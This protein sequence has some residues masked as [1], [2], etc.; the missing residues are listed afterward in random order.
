MYG[1]LENKRLIYAPNNVIFNGNKIFNPTKEILIELGY[2]P[3]ELG[4]DLQYKEGFYIEESYKIVEE[5]QT[6][7]GDTIPKH[8]E[9]V[10]EYVANPP[11]PEQ[12]PTLEE[13]ITN[14]EA[15]TDMLTQCVL[16]MSELVY[17]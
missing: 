9:R 17:V 1:K 6:P 13:R 10:Q 16:E 12:Q 11:E 7:E 5:Q 2:L 14:I 15:D 8:I 3:V 4:V